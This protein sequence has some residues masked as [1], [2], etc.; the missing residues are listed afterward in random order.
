M[1]IGKDLYFGQVRQVRPE[2]KKKEISMD[3]YK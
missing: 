3:Q 2:M 1:Y